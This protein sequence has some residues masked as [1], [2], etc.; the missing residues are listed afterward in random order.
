MSSTPEIGL[1]RNH[2]QYSASAGLNHWNVS[3][4]RRADGEVI[5]YC[6]LDSRYGNEDCPRFCRANSIRRRDN[7]WDN[8]VAVSS[9]SSLKTERTIKRIYNTR[10]PARADI[11]DYIEVSYNR[12]RHHSDLG[13]VSPENFEQASS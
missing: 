8:A 6:D 10:G 5:I 3:F 4:E 13:S 9:F 7:S 12:A 1:R 2:Y 11:F